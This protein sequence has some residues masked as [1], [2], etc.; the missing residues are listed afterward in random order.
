VIVSYL[1][2][3]GVQV[4]TKNEFFTFFPDIRSVSSVKPSKLQHVK[5]K[6][7]LP[8]SVASWL[9]SDPNVLL[10]INC[11][12]SYKTNLAGL[13]LFSFQDPGYLERMMNLL[14]LMD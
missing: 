4:D 9:G 7:G 1:V 2:V 12:V 3:S 13:M 11:P 14:P 8:Y 10:Y 5:L 6:F